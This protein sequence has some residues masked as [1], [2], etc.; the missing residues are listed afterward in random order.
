MATAPTAVHSK[1]AIEH[2]KAAALTT[3]AAAYSPQPIPDSGGLVLC[4][5]MRLWR[6]T[7][8]LAATDAAD[9]KYTGIALA[10]GQLATQTQALHE[11]AKAAATEY[12]RL[13]AAANLTPEDTTCPPCDCDGHK[14]LSA[15]E[16]TRRAA[17]WLLWPL[18][19]NQERYPALA[20]LWKAG[21]R[22]YLGE[23]IDSLANAQVTY[24]DACARLGTPPQWEWVLR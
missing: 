9:K 2:A 22:E 17:L 6:A 8:I 3:L 24:V 10:V 23:K 16:D 1:A 19:Q 7:E 21:K 15:M 5:E 18:E 14:M 11:K 4:P 12:R 20:A 13:C